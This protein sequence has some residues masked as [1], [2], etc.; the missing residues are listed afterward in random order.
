MAPIG[1]SPAACSSVNQPSALTSNTRSYSRGSLSARAR[2]VSIPAACRSRSILPLVDRTSSNTRATAPGVGQVDAV[3]ARRAPGRPHRFDRGQ[4]GGTPLE[5]GELL[6]DPHGRR[7]LACGLQPGGEV[8]LEPVAVGGEP[9]QVGI[10]RV[11]LRGEIEQVERRSACRGGQVRGDRR[12]DAARRPADHDGAV[13]AEPG[14]AGAVTE[15]AL[16]EADGEAQAVDVPGL[17]AAAVAQGLR[18]QHVGERG[19][20]P[21][22]RGSRRP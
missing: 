15:R 2:L 12:D 9:A 1:R 13:R 6:P 17:D 11:G 22:R 20:A 3:V 14:A 16:D 8:G 5:R 18:D 21:P 19:R 4:G 7:P 10:G